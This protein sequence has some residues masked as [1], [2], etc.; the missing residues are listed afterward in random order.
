MSRTRFAALGRRASDSLSRRR[1]RPQIEAL[2]ARQLLAVTVGNDALNPGFSLVQFTETAN[3]ASD[4]LTL[5]RGATGD[6]EYSFNGGAFTNDLNTSTAG[7]QSRAVSQVSGILVLAEAGDDTLSIDLSAGA[8]IP[9]LRGITFDGAAGSNDRLRLI[10]SADSDEVRLETSLLTVNA[11]PVLFGDVEHLTLDTGGGD[12]IVTILQTSGAAVDV[13]TQQGTGDWVLL[14]STLATFNTGVG[15][16]LDIANPV[17]IEDSDGAGIR[18]DDSARGLGHSATFS[19]T[20]T[21]RQ[22]TG[23]APVPIAYSYGVTEIQTVTGSGLDSL[24]LSFSGGSPLPEPAGLAYFTTGGDDELTASGGLVSAVTYTALPRV[25]GQNAGTVEW[26][27]DGDFSARF[28]YQGLAPIFDLVPAANRLFNGTA[29]ADEIRL[30]DDG[31][32]GNGRSRIDDNGTSAFE[33]VTFVHPT[34]QFTI[35]SGA[36]SD[37]LRIGPPEAGFSAAVQVLGGTE[38]DTFHVV[39]STTYDLTIAGG[40]PVVAPGDVL[41][42][43]LTGVTGAMVPAT[44]DGTITFGSGQRPIAYTSIETLPVI[45]PPG[46]RFESNNTL[47]TATVLGSPT[48]ATLDDVAITPGDIDFFRYAAHDTGSLSVRLYPAVGADSLVLTIRD[49]RN[50]VLGTIVAAGTDAAL[51]LPVVTQQPYLVQVNGVDANAD[52][53]YSL[54]IENFAA[55]VP[56]QVS[57]DPA[58]DSGRSP[59]DLVTRINSARI[60]ITDDLSQLG[61]AVLTPAQAAAQAP[62]AAVEVFVNGVSQGFASVVSGS[63]DTLFEFTF[64]GGGL[65][66]QGSPLVAAATRVFDGQ[67]D[68]GGAPTPATGR[69]GLS[70]P[71]A[72][73]VD[74]TAPLA[75]SV[76][77]LLSSSDTGGSNTDNRTGI[78]QPAFD[79]LGEAGAVVRVLANGRV[80]GTAL[81][82]PDFSD[83]VA[84]DGLGAWEVTVEPLAD[85]TYTITATLEDLAGNISGPSAAM[86]PTLVIDSTLGGGKPQRPTLDLRDAFD[87]GVSSL[88]NI[89][90]LVSLQ[91]R[92]TAEPGTMVVIKDG[93]T[94]IDGPFAMPAAPF[95]D[96]LLN[97][98]ALPAGLVADGTHLLSAEATDAAGNVSDQ[99]EELE[100]VIDRTAPPAPQKADLLASSDSG[101]FDDDDVTNKM[102][103]AFTALAESNTILRVFGTPSG[104]AAALIGQTTTGS[105]LSNKPEADQLGLWEVTVEPLRDGTYGIAATAEDLAGNISPLSMPL[106]VVIDTAAP[107]TPALDL[108]ASSDTGRSNVDNITRATL[109]VFASTSSE[110]IPAGDDPNAH[111][112]KYRIYDRHIDVVAPAQETLVV[113]SFVTLG[114]MVPAGLFNDAIA[115]LAEGVHHL[116]LEFEDRAGNISPD[117]LL[118][119][120]IDRTAPDAPTLSIDPAFSDTGVPGQPDTIVDQITSRSDLGYVG[121]A[122]ANAVVRVYADGE[123]LT[124]FNVAGD[125]LV[126]LTTSVPL[127]GNQAFPNGRWSVTTRWDLNNPDL[128]PFDGYRQLGATAED[129]AGNVSE[130]EFLDLLIDSQ[131][132]QVANV[133]PTVDPGFDLFQLKP[134][135]QPTPL[136]YSLDISLIDSPV[137]AV[138]GS[139][140]FDYPAANEI[141]AT[142]PGNY[143]LVG[144]HTGPVLITFVDF[145][146][147]TMTGTLGSSVVR[148]FFSEPLADDRYTLTISD[149]LTDD[150]GNRLDGES[151]GLGPGGPVFLPSGDGVPGGDFVARFTVDS[152]PEIA[153]FS[154]G[155]VTIDLNGNLVWDP[156]G[157][158]GD[159][160]NRDLQVTLGF[161]TDALFA[162]NF[163]ISSP[164]GFGIANGFDKL[165]AYGFV[166]GQWRWLIDMNG[167]NVVRASDGDIDLVQPIAIDG[168]PIAGNFDGNFFNG[169]EVGLFDGTTWYF[170]VNGDDVIDEFDFAMGGKLTGNL[171]G[172]PLVGD[173]D[174]DTLTD[175]ATYD[176]TANT[177]YF[178]LGWNGPDA[179]LDVVLGQPQQI[180]FVFGAQGELDWP[181]AADMDQDGIDDLGLWNPGR[182]TQPVSEASEWFFLIS[183]DPGGTRRQI[184]QVNTLNHPFQQQPLGPD[185]YAQWGDEFAL[186]LVGNF[187]P[188][189]AAAPAPLPGNELPPAQVVQNPELIGNFAFYNPANSTF[190]VPDPRGGSGASLTFVYGKP[191]SGW[192][193]IAGDWDGDGQKSV[194]FYDPATST[195]FLKNKLGPGLSDLVFSYGPAGNRW[196]PLVGDWDGNG[197]DGVGFY[198][199]DTSTW[200]L[201]NAHRQGLSDLTFAYGKAGA[202]WLPLVGDWDGDGR[203]GP[204]FFDPAANT[205]FLKNAQAQGMSDETLR[206][207]TSGAQLM[208]LVGDWLATGRDRPGWYHSA[209]GKFTTAA[210]PA[211]GTSERTF[212]YGPRGLAWNLLVDELFRRAADDE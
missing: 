143:R 209:T 186:P 27:K 18:I 206:L 113:D 49:L 50:N 90:R 2:E 118:T 153:D 172:I 117:F 42:L 71:L 205:W 11:A 211:S 123:P 73:T 195:W 177:F 193:P 8:V 57:L 74:T 83:G 1:F 155:N 130:A 141:V 159:R 170:D 99:S 104:G 10:G 148:L 26:V 181:V 20:G 96:R 29:G 36:G 48:T 91:F 17:T 132:P 35:D 198:D 142:Q 182:S 100:L 79:G 138:G 51:S 116:K 121:R 133:Y 31:T 94:V 68:A 92:V 14:G 171:R 167:D 30:T 81:V 108:L 120:I 199:P 61:L 9:T 103:P 28:Q 67:A 201:K 12:D 175:L 183:N 190:T 184:G 23:L 69:S 6:L 15:T 144:D 110:M 43:D 112:I 106:T 93:E 38:N 192:V 160:T 46:D 33:Q 163:G 37:T 114:G 64:G 125:T 54:E 34:N 25:S 176:N 58:S 32:P 95:V 47:A 145:I 101:M 124:L 131:G 161:P 109:P 202:G 126:G 178:S 111:L 134:V 164:V 128:F 21:A 127:D 173:F 200:F 187:D 19:N 169:D 191:N 162:G 107:N 105:D 88:D 196:V 72:L 129:V 174:G 78:H 212:R 152:R 41:N 151:N 115:G 16:L 156:Q 137:R 55:P 62:G 210:D 157:K 3:G 188:P 135:E 52:G 203:D 22:I 179:N 197:V 189:V 13:D 70:V 39:P 139:I 66:P 53:G 77:D 180:H 168:W 76:P 208:P 140:N 65:L 97:F 40:S 150:A 63:G 102:Q 84:G 204:G 185:L 136:I 80:V 165:G 82:G 59:V 44:P 166:N 149:R 119:V 89:T 122:E 154:Y 4:S 7:V 207:P 87:T 98:T 56:V 5:R 147:N 24:Q 158:D 86:S 75:P 45:L 194:G 60:R 85:R 146:D